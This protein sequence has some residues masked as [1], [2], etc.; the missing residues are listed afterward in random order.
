MAVYCAVNNRLSATKLCENQTVTRWIPLH[1][2][3]IYFIC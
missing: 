3:W 2:I 1:T